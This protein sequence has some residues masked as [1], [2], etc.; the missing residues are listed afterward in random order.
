MWEIWGSWE[1]EF[2]GSCNNSVF[3]WD[4]SSASTV[5]RGLSAFS[6]PFTFR[7]QDTVTAINGHELPSGKG[8]LTKRHPSSCSVVV[9]VKVLHEVRFHRRW[10]ISIFLPGSQLLRTARWIIS[11]LFLSFSIL[12][13]TAAVVCLEKLP[14]GKS[15]GIFSSLIGWAHVK[16]CAAQRLSEHGEVEGGPAAPLGRTAAATRCPWFPKIS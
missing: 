15:W 10:V 12:S 16:V 2:W 5:D 4:V 8:L 11:D 7:V 3:S 9:S 14:L 6:M 1:R 13:P